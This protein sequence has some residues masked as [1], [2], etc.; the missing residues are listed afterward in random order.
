MPHSHMRTPQTSTDLRPN[1]LSNLA[2]N[3]AFWLWS[4]Q[5]APIFA[6]KKG[7]TK[8]CYVLIARFAVFLS[9][10]A[11]EGRRWKLLEVGSWRMT[12]Y[13]CACACGRAFAG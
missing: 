5:I 11:T 10:F 9:R 7:Q 6:S 1:R 3:D 4:E 13:A 8:V 12:A 2:K